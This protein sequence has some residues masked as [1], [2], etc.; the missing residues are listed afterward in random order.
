M[1]DAVADAKNDGL[2][3]LSSVL[4]YPDPNSY[5]DDQDKQEVQDEITSYVEALNFVVGSVTK[6][7]HDWRDPWGLKIDS[8]KRITYGSNIHF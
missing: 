2:S 5:D 1:L 6:K 7:S 3:Q 8:S 4:V